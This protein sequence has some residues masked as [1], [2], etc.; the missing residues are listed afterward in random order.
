[1]SIK[2]HAPSWREPFVAAK[3]V[4][5]AMYLSSATAFAT[6]PTKEQ[7]VAANESA[8]YLRQASKLLEAR[9]QLLV[10]VS[11]ACP[12]PV[13]R[14]CAIRLS[15][16][17]TAM[18]SVIFEVK[19]ENVRINVDGKP[20]AGAPDVAIEVDPGEHTFTFEAPGRR[21]ERRL[22][23]L[24]GAKGRREIVVMTRPGGPS[25]LAWAAFGVGGISLAVGAIAWLVAGG[26]HATL[27]TECDNVAGTCAPQYS[28]DL[29]AFHTWRTVSTVGYVVGALGIAGGAI[30]WLTAPK[31]SNGATAR[32]WIGPTGA[33][34]DGWF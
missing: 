2:N 21:I 26:K 19:D 20:V 5:C 15:E 30:L 22:V 4:A 27:A 17:A 29:D 32:A 24:D 11:G 3:L 7:C 18:P 31:S 9:E 10:C 28:S 14:D 33:G 34:V 1:V 8:Q 13:R 23:V 25:P 12:D 6:P 16:I